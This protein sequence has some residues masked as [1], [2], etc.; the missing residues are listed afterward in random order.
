MFEILLKLIKPV[1]QVDD[2]NI[3]TV[4]RQYYNLSKCECFLR[5]WLSDSKSGKS[6]KREGHSVGSLLPFKLSI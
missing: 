1:S 2:I 4:F 5:F 3:N 6:G